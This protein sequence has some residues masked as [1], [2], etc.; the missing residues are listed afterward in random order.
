MF[1]TPM[2]LVDPATARA[3]K[4]GEAFA[5]EPG[6][7]VQFVDLDGY[8][9]LVWFDARDALTCSCGGRRLQVL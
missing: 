9:T 8:S 7:R 4:A 3:G 5:P 1:V 6:D 2:S